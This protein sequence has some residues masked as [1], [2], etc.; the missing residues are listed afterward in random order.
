MADIAGKVGEL[1]FTLEITRA[2]GDVEVVQMVGHVVNQEEEQ[3]GS[4]T[5]DSSS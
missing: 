4:N 3:N 5:L 1:S 2:N